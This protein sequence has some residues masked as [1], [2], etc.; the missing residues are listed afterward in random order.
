MR[1]DEDR[2][3]SVDQLPDD[4]LKMPPPYWRSCSAIFHVEEALS[5]LEQLLQQ[6]IPIH[7]K[8][9]GQLEEYYERHPEENSNEEVLEKFADITAELTDIEHRVQL[10]AELACLMSAIETE[11]ALNRFCVFNLHR[12]L[13]ESIEK[14]SPPEK[15]LVAAAAVGKPGAKDT[16]VFEAVRRLSVWRNAFA[17]G[18][19]V[20][21]PT[22]SLRHNHL[23]LPEEHPGVPSALAEMRELVGAFLRVSDYLKTIS[24]NPYTKGKSANVEDIRQSLGRIARYR[25][26]G[27]T[28]VYD[29]TLSKAE[30]QKIGKALASLAESG[31][32]TQTAK[33]ENI[34]A[35]LDLRRGQLLRLEL[36]IEDG[37]PHSR[38]EIMRIMKISSPALARERAIALTRLAGA[39]DF[40]TDEAV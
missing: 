23:I 4:P 13:A 15:L 40:W 24:V 7:G 34:L 3:V 39:I 10:K 21:R 35:T 33:L 38:M 11:D 27:N 8:T 17:H 5:E 30:Q 16:S 36:G 18:H 12:D 9:E 1:R 25:F 37:H 22:K 28:Y 6:L 29:V 14:L 20:D 31:D 19:C 2:I 26:D 32:E